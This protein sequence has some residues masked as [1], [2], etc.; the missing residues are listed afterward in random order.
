METSVGYKKTISLSCSVLHPIGKVRTKAKIDVPDSEFFLILLGTDRLEKLF[1]LIRT[2]VGTDSNFDILQLAGRAS[3]LT[4]VYIILGLKSHWDRGPR[5]LKLPAVIKE[6]GDVS[7]Q[8]D[9]ISPASWIGDLHV[10]DVVL[11]TC[12]IAG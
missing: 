7:N 8:A 5:R 10:A 1:G 11:Q 6:R 12:W 4:E 2:A 3:N 9:H